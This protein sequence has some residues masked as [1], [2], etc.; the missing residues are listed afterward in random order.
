M[1]GTT[2]PESAE[3]FIMRIWFSLLDMCMHNEDLVSTSFPSL[4]LFFDLWSTLL[5]MPSVEFELRTEQ[6]WL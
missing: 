3:I 6:F 4:W 2:S 1:F 5:Q